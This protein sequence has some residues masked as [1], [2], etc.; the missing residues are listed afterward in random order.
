MTITRTPEVQTYRFLQVAVG[1]VTFLLPFDTLVYG[2]AR[3]TPVSD[4]HTVRVRHI[5]MDSISTTYYTSARGFFVGSLCALGFLF[6]AYH[7]RG[8]VGAS[9]D[10]SWRS[11]YRT[12]MRLSL[13]AAGAAVLV[14]LVPTA[15]CENQARRA[16]CP[17]PFTSAYWPTFVHGTATAVLMLSIALVCAR[18]FV[19]RASAEG[20]KRGLV[21]R[22][23]GPL[24]RPTATAEARRANVVYRLGA[25][26]IVLAV[27]LV[28][29]FALLD[30]GPH[31]HKRSVS[32]VESIAV[33]SFGL[34][35][36]TKSEY[37]VWRPWP[38][39]PRVLPAVRSWWTRT[40]RHVRPGPA[41]AAAAP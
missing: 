12:D 20:G 25:L 3:G 5:I 27:L 26:T 17:K 4:G 18:Q 40:K 34:C 32:W 14:A 10:P 24:P 21:R 1:L 9:D 36:M 37:L 29:V 23:S 41:P 13:T 19:P 16:E 39:M 30:R 38:A 15:N 6:G 8:R 33:W 22:I 2:W 28:G 31:L 11:K 7:R 35:W